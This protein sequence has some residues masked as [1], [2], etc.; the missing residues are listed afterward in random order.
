MAPY[1]LSDMIQVYKGL[2]ITN[3]WED[4]IYT[5][6]KPTIFTVAAKLK[7]LAPYPLC[8]SMV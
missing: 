7:A 3:L 8:A 6:Y 2:K 1:S 4:V 5:L